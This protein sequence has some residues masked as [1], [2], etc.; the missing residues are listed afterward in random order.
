[1]IY[2]ATA[3]YAIF[4]PVSLVK[5]TVAHTWQFTAYVQNL[6]KQPIGTLNGS[7]VTGVKV[8]ISDFHVT[9]GTGTVSVANADGTSTFTA[10][11]QPYFNYN[12]IV[13]PSGYTSNKLWK[14]NVPNTVTAVSMSILIS[15]DF[16]AEQNV[17]ALPPATKPTW[18]SNDSSWVG[19]EHNDFLKRVITLCFRDATTLPDRQLA[20]AYVNGTVVG[21]APMSTGDGC[22]YVQVA[23]DGSGTQLDGA[24]TRLKTL[25]QVEVAAPTYGA[26]PASLKPRDGPNWT[27][28]KLWPDSIGEEDNWALEA[29][30][31]PMA[32]GCSTGSTDAQI[33]VIDHNFLDEEL[34]SNVASGSSNLNAYPVDTLQHGARVSAVLAARGNNSSGMT[35]VMWRAG[36]R[37]VELSDYYKPT[38][39]DYGQLIEQEGTAGVKVVNISYWKNW[40]RRLSTKADTAKVFEAF[41]AMMFYLRRSSNSKHLPLIVTVAGDSNFD[42]FQ[43]VM[44]ILHDSLPLRSLIVAGSTRK[45]THSTKY[46]GYGRLVDVYA[47]GEDLTSN[48]IQAQ[49]DTVVEGSA[50]GT[51]FSA[52]LVAGTAGLL[53]SFDSTIM[54]DSLRAYILEGAERGNRSITGPDGT[55]HYL[56]NAYESLKRAAERPGAPLCGNRVWSVNGRVV[57][58]RDSTV[59]DTLFSTGESGGYMTVMHGGHRIDF[60]GDSSFK[61]RAFVLKGNAWTEAANP[62]TLPSA[63]TGGSAYSELQLSHNGDSVVLVQASQSATAEQFNVSVKAVATGTTHSLST[64]TVPLANNTS[65]FC[66]QQGATFHTDTF[67]P[68]TVHFTGYVCGDT[69]GVDGSFQTADARAAY[70]PLGDRVIVTINRRTTQTTAIQTWQTCPWSTPDPSTGVQQVQCRSSSYQE[71]DSAALVYGVRTADGVATQLPSPAAGDVFWSAVSEPG[72]EL[73]TGIG[74]ITTTWQS[75]PLANATWSSTNTSLLV[76]NCRLEYRTLATGA[77]NL[78]VATN[79]PCTAG[80][81]EGTGT[82]SPRRVANSGVY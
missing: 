15:T 43:S 23:D 17:T 50:D 12:Q 5:D 29:I 53:L 47:P 13:T 67:P 45:R 72:V 79:D 52:P 77:V 51:S 18:F 76:N 9:A 10:P 60:F 26:S 61:S 69:T 16:P 80:G 3:T 37:L 40:R 21:G 58:M 59:R 55:Q 4:F 27:E 65:H 30:N 6:L 7:T 78:T 48:Y 34:S 62:D 11:N 68:F 8:F 19:P 49:G 22:Y 14:F 28:W 32:W 82:F 20:V 46:S 35:G 63:I 41:N 39:A 57:A 1:V 70:S 42:A 24:V 81:I 64:I 54:V 38:F 31:A 71:T 75:L 56:T 44:P 33:S 25:P 36:L 66:R 74:A 73:V 2:G